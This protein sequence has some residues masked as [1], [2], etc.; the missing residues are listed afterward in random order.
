M[1]LSHREDDVR[2]HKFDHATTEQKVHPGQDAAK[3][4]AKRLRDIRRMGRH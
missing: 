3:S 1:R 2:R 4:R